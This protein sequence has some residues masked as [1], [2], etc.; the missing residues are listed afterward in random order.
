[1][2]RWE[3]GQ[4]T[5]V[6]VRGTDAVRFLNGQVTQDV[7]LLARGKEH[8]LAACLTDAKGRLQAH[9]T[10]YQPTD[11]PAV[12]WLESDASL[13]DVVLNRLERYLIADEVEIVDR[14]EEFWLEHVLGEAEPQPVVGEAV[15]KKFARAGR[16]GWDVWV[17]SALR[18]PD[19]AAGDDRSRWSEW[20]RVRV[21]RAVPQWGSE[22]HE[23]MLVAEAGLDQVAISYQKGCYIG[24]EV[25]SRIKTAGKVPRRLLAFEL[26]AAVAPWGTAIELCHEG[27]SVGHI[28]SAAGQFA[29]GYVERRAEGVTC[30]DAVA[31]DG[32]QVQGGVR[33]RVVEP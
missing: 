12:V 11:D 26:D 1:M 6:E 27:R 19:P 18:P 10:L 22:L 9:L 30:F 17:A 13:R 5:L 4:R 20:E 31:A 25:I 21:E 28:T 8:A 2:Q 24:Q 16:A 33:T 15:K 14:S 29:L 7:R 23:G 3:W 32:R